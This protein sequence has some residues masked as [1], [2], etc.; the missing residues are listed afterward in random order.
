MELFEVF[1]EG[2][3]GRL[4]CAGGG[5]GA[6]CLLVVSVFKYCL[7]CSDSRFNL[8]S[9]SYRCLSLSIELGIEL[10]EKWGDLALCPPKGFLAAADD[11]MCC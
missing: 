5:G 4:P 10:V 11:E 8:Q 6:P 1:E 9:L 2:L 3:L 7:L